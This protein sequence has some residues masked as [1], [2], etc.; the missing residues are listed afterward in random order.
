M[1]SRS[2][3]DAEKLRKSEAAYLR[4]RDYLAS[5]GRVDVNSAALKRIGEIINVSLAAKPDPAMVVG[6]IAEILW[7]LEEPE[8]IVRDYDALKSRLE[9]RTA[10]A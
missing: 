4:A 6:R 5:T 9:A 8:R 2:N 1:D 3:S 10:Q 7:Q